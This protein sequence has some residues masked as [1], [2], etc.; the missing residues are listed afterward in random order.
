MHLRSEVE[1]RDIDVGILVLLESFIQTQKV[2]TAKD[3]R[4]KFH[5]YLVPD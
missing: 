2:S 1:K 4:R 3:L 5:K